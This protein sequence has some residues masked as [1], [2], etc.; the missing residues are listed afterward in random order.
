MG[1]YL[2]HEVPVVGTWRFKCD[3]DPEEI[4][5][6]LERSEN[7]FALLE[8]CEERTYDDVPYREGSSRKGGSDNR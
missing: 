5:S 1:N 6:V 3:G 8:D 7:W 2:D 4:L